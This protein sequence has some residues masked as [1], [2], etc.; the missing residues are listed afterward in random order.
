MPSYPSNTEKS[1]AKTGFLGNTP[2]FINSL[3]LICDDSSQREIKETWP[4]GN[5]DEWGS[6][7]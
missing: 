6:R 1:K 5:I 7:K 3:L 2:R 4:A